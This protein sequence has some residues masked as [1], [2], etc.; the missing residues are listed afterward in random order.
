[1]GMTSIPPND[2][3]RNHQSRSY[4][5]SEEV[6]ILNFIVRRRVFSQCKGNKLWELMALTQVLPNRTA[7][8]MKGRFWK[9]IFQKLDKFENLSAKDI[10]NITNPPPDDTPR[11]TEKDGQPAIQ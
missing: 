5:Y 3:S 10:E 11:Y 4:T 1:M 7:Q 2:L 9:H 8:S 6:A